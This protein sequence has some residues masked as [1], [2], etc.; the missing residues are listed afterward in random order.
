M[1]DRRAIDIVCSGLEE[2]TGFSRLQ[3]H[4]TM[5]LALKL[6]GFDPNKVNVAEIRIVVER[7][8]PDELKRRN[9]D[10]GICRELVARLEGVS[11]AE[12]SEND[13]RPEAVFARFGTSTH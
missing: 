10:A 13:I 4:G 3:A 12:T 5:R 1:A 2:L 11:D 7:V 6:A 8:L 9:R